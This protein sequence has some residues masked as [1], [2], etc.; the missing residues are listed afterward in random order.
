[1]KTNLPE[2]NGSGYRLTNRSSLLLKT[3]NGRKHEII[4]ETLISSSFPNGL[5]RAC[6][7][8]LGWS[9]KYYVSVTGK[10]TAERDAKLAEWLALKPELQEV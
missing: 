9:K 6:G 10:D 1:M 4:I 3:K 7:G 5:H 2:I 8:G